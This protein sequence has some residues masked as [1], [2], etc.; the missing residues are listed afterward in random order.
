MKITIAQIMEKIK[1]AHD[2]NER[3]K[4][5]QERAAIESRE[6]KRKAD[7]AAAAG[8]IDGYLRLKQELDRQEAVAYV[9]KT[10][11]ERQAN[12]VSQEEITAAWDGYSSDYVKKMNAARKEYQTAKT[13]ALSA[14]RK[15]LDLQHEALAQREKLADI[16]GIPAKEALHISPEAERAFPMPYIFEGRPN[17]LE[18]VFCRL[19]GF[20]LL[21][22]DL[23]FYI[24][25]LG[26]SEMAALMKDADTNRII[27]E[28]NNHCCL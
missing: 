14:F 13:A 28:I 7:E 22:P 1:S 27:C 19:G 20:G 16:A 17:K 10:Q 9:R 5:E 6:L 11:L 15:L 26:Y 21:H 2:A 3:M 23:A 18:G 4:Q 8:D 24:G 12:P 25:N